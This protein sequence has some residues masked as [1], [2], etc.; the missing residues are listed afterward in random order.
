MFKQY[1]VILNFLRAR[2]TMV[3]LAPPEDCKVTQRVSKTLNQHSL[4]LLDH[5][6]KNLVKDDDDAIF[7]RQSPRDRR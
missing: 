5:Q 3:H 4:V 1:A 7:Q 2:T 6:L